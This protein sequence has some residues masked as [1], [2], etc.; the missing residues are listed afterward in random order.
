M[1]HAFKI[2]EPFIFW[3]DDPVI[4]RQLERVATDARLMPF[5]ESCEENTKAYV[6]AENELVIKAE[7][8]PLPKNSIIFSLCNPIATIAF[9]F[10]RTRGRISE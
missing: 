10:E 9:T 7:N 8:S 4:E 5:A 6:D 3:Q 2:A 1:L